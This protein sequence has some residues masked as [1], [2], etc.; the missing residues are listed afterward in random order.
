MST[1]ELVWML[2]FILGFHVY[3]I[4]M[5]LSEKTDLQS[6]LRGKLDF[7]YDFLLT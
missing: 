5:R 3:I 4:L 7:S 6:C 1:E 2:L